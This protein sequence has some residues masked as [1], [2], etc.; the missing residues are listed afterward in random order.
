M[1]AS[2]RNIGQTQY[3]NMT[4]SSVVARMPGATALQGALADRGGAGRNDPQNSHSS[5]MPES[6]RRAAYNPG[7]IYQHQSNNEGRR[8]GM[9]QELADGPPVNEGPKHDVPRPEG[10]APQ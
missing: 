7:G 10:I 6:R 2:S 8:N 9:Q 3:L 1:T 4:S 5:G